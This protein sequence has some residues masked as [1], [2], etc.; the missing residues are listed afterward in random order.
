MI[1]LLFLFCI[2]ASTYAYRQDL[3]KLPNG[4]SYG[5]TLGHPGG[6]TKVPTKLASTFYQAS[7]TWMQ[8]AMVNRMV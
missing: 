6:N 7:Q 2:I 5:L 1:R 8:M 3:A 4:N